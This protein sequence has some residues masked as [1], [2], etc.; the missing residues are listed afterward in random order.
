M[1]YS[2]VNKEFDD[3]SLLINRLETNKE[4]PYY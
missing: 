3:F 4:M 2:I 1:T